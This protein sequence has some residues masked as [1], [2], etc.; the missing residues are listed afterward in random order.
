[1]LGRDQRHP[2]WTIQGLFGKEAEA[3]VPP[4]SVWVDAKAD[5]LAYLVVVDESSQDPAFMLPLP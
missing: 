1:M 5:F 2:G 4:G 3:A